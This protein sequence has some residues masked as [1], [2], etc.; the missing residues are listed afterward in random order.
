LTDPVEQKY[1]TFGQLFPYLGLLAAAIGAFWGAPLLGRE[2]ESGTSKL[3]WTQSVPRRSWMIVKISTLGGLAAV[4][5]AML[6]VMVSGWLSVFAGFAVPGVDPDLSFTA[7][8]G[9]APFAWWLFGFAVGV[10]MGALTRRTVPAMA[11]TVAVVVGA[12]AL[13]NAFGDSLVGR[14][15]TVATDLPP[16]AALPAGSVMSSLT[17]LDPAGNGVDDA[18]IAR[19]IADS[20]PVGDDAALGDAVWDQPAAQQCLYALGYRADVGYIPSG[21]FWRLE[22]AQLFVQLAVSLI[23]LVG[24]VWR[25]E[26]AAA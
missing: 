1:A 9:P 6:G 5:G 8:R 10:A 7:I 4:G 2:F 17:W 25:V 21:A 11:I 22:L 19:L 18:E 24:T 15:F 16:E 26:R 20:C 12:L 14:Q 3:A 13:S 23:L